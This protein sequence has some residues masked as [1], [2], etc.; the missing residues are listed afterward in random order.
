MPDGRPVERW[1][2]AGG[3]IEV[4][5]LTWGGIVQA[6][7]VPDREGRVEDVALGFDG[8]EDYLE[9]NRYCG[10]LV[11]RYANRIAGGRFTL[12]GRE[13]RLP[14]NNG[15]NSIHGGTVGFDKRLWAAEEVRGQADAGVA[16]RY[17]S[18]DGEMGYP[19]T[20][21]VTVRYR[22]D[23]A[24][25]LTLD[26]AATTDRPTVLNLTNHSYFNLAGAGRGRVLDQVAW[27]DADRVTPVDEN[28]IPTGALAPV[29][30]TPLDFT[31]PAA[32]GARIR[33]DDP[34][35]KRAEPQDGGY[36]FNYVLNRP[37][38][39]S[40]P[41]ARVTDPV[42]GRTVECFTTEPGLQFYTSNF[43]RGLPGKDGRTY[44]HWGAFTL[45]AQHF[46]DSPNR[47]A[48]PSTVLRPGETYRQTTIYRFFAA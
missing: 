43:I 8:L 42:S 12:D 48:F 10:A 39:L 5:V 33:A 38:D 19:G 11:G 4:A 9:R 16:L 21:D 41:A 13:H 27:I 18:P 23:E 25:R 2:L 7:R 15:P 14:V 44:D 37:G 3:G 47:P 17:R 29:A 36:D 1:R 46:P 34:Q 28:L 22:L 24:G 31:S 40:A 35:L 32:I 6:I 26:Y 30:G 20:L 45:E